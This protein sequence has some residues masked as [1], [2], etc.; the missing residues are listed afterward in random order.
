MIRNLAIL[1]ICAPLVGAC[2]Q[3]VPRDESRKE[4][5]GSLDS[6]A[7]VPAPLVQPGIDDP[8]PFIAHDE[9]IQLG[10]PVHRRSAELRNPYE[11]NARMIAMGAKLF[12]AYN[13]S[14]CH[15]ADA[16]GAMAP[17]LQDGR[18]HFGGSAGAVFQSVYEGRPDG[19]PAWGGRIADEQIWMLV[20]YVRSLSAGKDVT[21]EN[22]SGKTVERTGH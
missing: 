9:N 17:S 19:M 1:A 7:A 20:A 6:S 13:C 21:T 3:R 10:L 22:F 15:G 5:Q 12:V 4:G 14:D 16:S 2:E 11:R 18:W 8:R